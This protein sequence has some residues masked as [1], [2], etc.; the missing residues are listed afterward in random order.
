MHAYSV[1]HR[2]L[3]DACPGIHRR[4]LHALLLAVEALVH[5][6]RLTLSELGRHLPG[7]ARHAIKRIDRLL[8]NRHLHTERVGIYRALAAH[9]LGEQERPIV[10][11]DWSDLAPIGGRRTHLVLKAA[12]SVR[13]RAITL[14][15]EVHTV[16]AYNR[17]S[18]HRRFLTRFASVLPEHCRPILVTD[19]GFRGPWFQAVEAQRWDWLGRVRGVVHHSTDAGHSW[20][21]ASTLHP[22]ATARARTIGRAWLGKRQCVRAT[23]VLV[24]KYVRTRGR[25]HRGNGSAAKAG[26]KRHKEPWVLATSLDP[27]RYRPERLVALYARRMQIELTFRDDK[28]CRFGW[29]L[30]YSGSRTIERRQ[31]LLLIAALATLVAGLAGMAAER[32][33]HARALHGGPSRRRRT[34]S[35]VFTGRRALQRAPPW[36]TLEM[37]ESILAVW[38]LVLMLTTDLLFDSVCG[39]T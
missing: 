3:G 17:A 37:L 8:G 11:I 10:L 14:Y 5:G 18:V 30:D 23:L 38:P 24:R 21:L 19:A 29:Q 27:A 12:L 7:C 22:Q 2:W 35:T 6:Q 16:R 32:D 39:E 28:G 26:R 34:H 9:L 25:P 15:E 1:L 20:Q 13:G 4:R 31:V 33:A 36:L